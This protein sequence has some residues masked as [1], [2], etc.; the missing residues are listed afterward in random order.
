[1]KLNG[2]QRL[3]IVLS[4]IYFLAVGSYGVLAFPDGADLEKGRAILAVELSLKALADSAQAT[5]DV[6]S[7]LNALR[8]MKDGPVRIRSEIYGDLKD[9]ELINRAR[10]KFDGKVDFSALDKR[11]TDDADRLHHDRLEHVVR[12]VAW[13]IVPLLLLYALGYAIGWVIRG[14]RRRSE[15]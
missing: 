8:A 1:M 7:E 15:P 12:C 13:W 11:E 14:F 2:W 3:W 9:A 10:A 5:G 6:R 4:G